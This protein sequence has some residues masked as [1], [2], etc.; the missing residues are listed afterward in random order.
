M[1]DLRPVLT[2]ELK[3]ELEGRGY[4]ILAASSHRSAQRRHR[5]RAAELEW[6]TRD[7]DQ[8]ERWARDCLGEERRLRDRCEFL[9]GAATARG[10]TAEELRG[11][12]PPPEP[13]GSA[14]LSGAGGPNPAGEEVDR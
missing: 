7:R 1:T 5:E 3:A 12:D 14:M 13:A 4:A 10:A 9:Y 8:A 6:V 11:L 2:G